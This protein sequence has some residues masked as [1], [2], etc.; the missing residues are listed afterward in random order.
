M[1]NRVTVGVAL[2]WLSLPQNA[3]FKC[4][5]GADLELFTEKYKLNFFSEQ[6]F[7]YRL[8]KKNLTHLLT[9]VKSLNGILVFVFKTPIRNNMFSEFQERSDCVTVGQTGRQ[10]RS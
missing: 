2:G 7:R 3:V 5:E 1:E 4:L 6:K 9:S 8:E 10:G